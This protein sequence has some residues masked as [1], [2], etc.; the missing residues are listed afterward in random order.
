MKTWSKSILTGSGL[1]VAAMMMSN[2]LNLIFN[3][4][5]GRHLQFDDFGVIAI[6]NTLWYFINI[7]LTALSATT[8]HEVAY[9]SSKVSK[10]AGIRFFNSVRKNVIV[11]TAVATVIYLL[12][13]PFLRSYFQLQTLKILLLFTPIIFAGSIAA[14]YRGFLYG[15]FM[16]FYLATITFMEALAKLVFAY[17]LIK[18]GYD[19]FVFLAIPLAIVVSAI[20][21]VYFVSHVDT[22]TDDVG[23]YNFPKRFYLATLIT[24]LANNVFLS[25][26]ITLAKHYLDPTLA[27]KYAMLALVGKMIYFLGSLITSFMI[28]FVSRDEG[29]GRNPVHTFYRLFLIIFVLVSGAAVGL[30]IFGSFF[31]PL[32]FGVRTVSIIPYLMKY[33]AAIALFTLAHAI[34]VYHLARKQYLFP[35]VA[36][37]TG[38]TMALKIVA[39]HEGIWDIVDAMFNV[40]FVNFFLMV[41]LH[42][43]QKDGGAITRNLVDLFFLFIPLPERNPEKINGKRILIFNWRDTR[44]VFAGGAE[45]YIHELAKRWVQAGNKVTLFC[46]NDGKTQRYEIIDGVEI[47]RRGGFYFVYFWAVVYYIFKF[48]NRYDIIIDSENGIPFFTPLYA[49]EKIYLL[50]HHVHQDVFLKSLKPPFSWLASFLEIVFMPHV[51]QKIQLITVSPSSKKDIMQYGLTSIEP[52]II[53]NGV[54]LA[55]LKQ[56]P[57]DKQPTVLYLGRLKYYKSVHV[58]IH[59]AKEILKKIPNARFIIAGDGEEKR[60]LKE[61]AASLEIEHAIEFTGKV[62]DEMKI[63]LYQKAWVFV[64]PS[65]MEGWGITSIEANACGT[66]VVAANVPGLKDSVRDTISG[67]L[68]PFG[69]VDA[70]AEKIIMLLSD[71]ALRTKMAGQ[72]R[73][74][75]EKYDWNESAKKSLKLFHDQTS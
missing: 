60:K 9:L 30:G 67:Y 8:T 57:K 13:T 2:I 49:K 75:A 50:I 35:I 34:V 58:F 47:I 70:F 12:A 14:L 4:F 46:G 52:V 3:V 72:A 73:T 18:T 6:I 41:G 45:V 65:F 15:H 63:S 40:A 39:H 29:S 7:F 23:N 26:D 27:G 62:T 10:H 22:N 20:L 69:K 59:A 21:A 68:V 48:R 17:G 25:F 51:Y 74:W 43:I 32:I 53:Y 19:D 71:K 16:F 55:T 44:H 36:I 24:G 54:D 31:V 61:L 56:A 11:I 37:L 33:S 64:N 38:L 1:L 28:A 42:F 66:P 5:L